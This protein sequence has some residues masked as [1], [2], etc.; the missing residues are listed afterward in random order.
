MDIYVTPE[1]VAY[2]LMGNR[3]FLRVLQKEIQS[4]T[5]KGG[6]PRIIFRF[7]ISPNGQLIGIH[8]IGEKSLECFSQLSDSL[9]KIKFYP[10]E[11]NGENVYMLLS[12]TV[13]DRR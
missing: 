8:P 7:V 9:L 6:D 13:N 10:A 3:A 12:A 1:F 2:P 11:H 4:E 5:C